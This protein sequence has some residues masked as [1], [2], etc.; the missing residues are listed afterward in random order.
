MNSLINISEGASLALHSLVLIA[1]NSPRRMNAKI[2]AE[3]LNASQAHLS[4]IFQKLSKANLVKSVRGPAG[5]FELYKP[6]EEISFL[7][8]YEIIEGKVNLS[9]CSLGKFHCAFATCIFNSEL[10]R[11]SAD[12]YRTLK[13]MKLSDFND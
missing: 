13:N 3:Q 6:A 1:K 8:I 4:K 7:D 10:N 9:A 11:I 2:I 12:I 5:G